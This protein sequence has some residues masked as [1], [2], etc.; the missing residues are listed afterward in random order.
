MLSV[1][2]AL[3]ISIP[4]KRTNPPE[5][6]AASAIA[7]DAASGRVL[8]EKN[9]DTPRFPA[10][11]TKIM[12]TLLVMEHCR[13][14]EIITAPPEIDKVAPSSMHLKPGEKV[15]AHDLVYAMMLRSAN[16]GCVAAADHISGSVDDFATLMN[17][18]AK[19]IG[20]QH[21]HF[22]NP[23]GLPDPFHKTTAR[24]LALIAREAMKLPPFQAVVRTREYTIQRSIN[25]ADRHMVSRNKLLYKD[26]TADGIKTGFTDAAG[27]CYVGSATRNG[28][29]VITVLLKSDHWQLDHNALLDYSF[30]NFDRQTLAEPGTP[31]LDPQ[32]TGGTINHVPVEPIDVRSTVLEK[33][34]IPR[35]PEIQAKF[36]IP[37]K[38]PIEKGQVVGTVAI[39][40][41]NGITQYVRIRALEDVPLAPM[42]AVSARLP[43]PTTGFLGGALILGTVWMRRRAAKL[44]LN[45]RSTRF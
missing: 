30:R 44:T 35:N 19:E 43:S 8:W 15:S 7:I 36:P 1:A 32:V 2:V 16:D 25:Q 29:R 34:Q 42:A 28:Y 37:L 13:P 9:A 20:C 21:T 3:S 18:R 12:T 23:N 27:H 10:S 4:G 41:Q 38:A 45:G 39:R 11:T 22:H 40:D 24:D 26:P 17:Q 5:V 33:G 6:S 14:E 31:I